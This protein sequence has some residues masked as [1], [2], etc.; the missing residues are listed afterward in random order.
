MRK[1]KYIDVSIFRKFKEPIEYT[2]VMDDVINKYK[3]SNLSKD[4]ECIDILVSALFW[5]YYFKKAN[6]KSYIEPGMNARLLMELRNTA[7]TPEM[8][9]T[10][11]WNVS[12]CE[13]PK[14]VIAYRAREINKKIPVYHEEPWQF[15][16]YV[17][18]R[19]EG[20]YR[21]YWRS[22]FEMCYA[23]GDLS[24]VLYFENY[25]DDAVDAHL[26]GWN[27]VSTPIRE[28]SHPY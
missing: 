18:S 26:D 15:Y 20:E 2:D 12:E 5:D 13:T 14:Q 3:I 28:Y 27:G 8:P 21:D 24:K 19:Q 6:Y 9:L 10:Y 11:Y 22:D 4:D 1:H 23:D 25:L 16:F 7:M 17:L